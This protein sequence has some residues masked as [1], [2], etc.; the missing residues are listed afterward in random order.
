MTAG[1]GLRDLAQK[2]EAIARNHPE[3]SRTHEIVLNCTGH[4]RA[5]ARCVDTVRH[6]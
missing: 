6:K 1:D 5:I 2:I 4:L 3:W